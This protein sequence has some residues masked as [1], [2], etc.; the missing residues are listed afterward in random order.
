MPAASMASPPLMRKDR[1]RRSMSTV[2]STVDPLA[3]LCSR[4]S[5][6]APGCGPGQSASWDVAKVLRTCPKYGL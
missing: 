1:V 2:T 4:S 5:W 6:A 3:A